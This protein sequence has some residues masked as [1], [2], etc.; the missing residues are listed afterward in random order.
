M[1]VPPA[2]ASQYIVN[3]LTGVEGLAALF[4]THPSTAERIARLT[5]TAVRR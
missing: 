3:P 2:R 5:G 4:R 1:P